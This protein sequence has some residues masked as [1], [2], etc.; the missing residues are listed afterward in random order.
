M[1]NSLIEPAAL[2]TPRVFLKSNRRTL[3]IEL[4]A[5][6]TEALAREAHYKAKPVRVVS[7]GTV[8]LIYPESWHRAVRSVSVGQ[9]FPSAAQASRVLGFDHNR[10]AIALSQA[11]RR[12]ARNS[13]S[14]IQARIRGV[15]LEYVNNR[16]AEQ[17]FSK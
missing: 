9:I 13:N 14:P 15:V 8:G 3:V 16:P 4:P 10:V 1:N 12:A 6:F 11:K 2:A 17:P 5:E 7:V